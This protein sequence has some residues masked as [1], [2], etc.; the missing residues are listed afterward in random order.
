MEQT[1]FINVLFGHNK[2]RIFDELS[3]VIK[4]LPHYSQQDYRFQIH[5]FRINAL[6]EMNG[7]IFKSTYNENKLKDDIKQHL[8]IMD[9]IRASNLE[10]V[11]KPFKNIIFVNYTTRELEPALKFGRIRL[12]LCDFIN[13]MNIELVTM[14]T[15]IYVNFM[16]KAYRGV[17]PSI[18]R[19]FMNYTILSFYDTDADRRVGDSTTLDI[20][21]ETDDD[22]TFILQT[23]LQMAHI[24][25]HKTNN[26]HDNDDDDDYQQYGNLNGVI[27]LPYHPFKQSL[28]MSTQNAKD[29]INAILMSR[30]KHLIYYPFDQNEWLMI[31]RNIMYEHVFLNFLSSSKLYEH[32]KVTIQKHLYRNSMSYN[33]K[34]FRSTQKRN[35]THTLNEIVFN[36]TNVFT[37]NSNVYGS[38]Y[39]IETRFINL[40]QA[41]F[42]TNLL[43]TKTPS[44]IFI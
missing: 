29:N 2:K 10:S 16:K 38:W 24:T 19:Y 17:I 27:I 40:A 43:C 8:L 23:R 30:D 44:G 6:S 20:G 37:N 25:D 26:K 21:E 33:Y 1:F 39:N 9:D 18:N 31:L 41:P 11:S 12:Y 32:E 15:P 13:E 42:A 22:I 28:F 3:K 5:P 34:K 36:Y 4:Q 14:T 35:K 7:N